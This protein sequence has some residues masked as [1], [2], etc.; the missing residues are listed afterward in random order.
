MNQ[1]DRIDIGEGEQERADGGGGGAIAKCRTARRRKP[2]Y[3]TT[4]STDIASM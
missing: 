1:L 3:P 2:K 4:A